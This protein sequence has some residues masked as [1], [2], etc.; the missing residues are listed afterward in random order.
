MTTDILDRFTDR[1]ASLRRYEQV[2]M[3][4]HEDIG[5]DGTA[6][7]LGPLLEPVKIGRLVFITEEHGLAAIAALDH[8]GRNTRQVKARFSWHRDIL[9]N[10]ESLHSINYW[11]YK[12][13]D[14]L[15]LIWAGTP[16]R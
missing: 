1:I 8:M 11:S 12:G 7:L 10:V 9:V 2:D 4:G 15:C 3:I 13:T 16:G 5:V 14:P 6:M